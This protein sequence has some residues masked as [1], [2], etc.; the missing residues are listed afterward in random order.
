[1][2]VRGV[3]V[4]GRRRVFW[5]VGRLCVL[6]FRSSYGGRFPRDCRVSRDSDKLLCT[7][8]LCWF[9]FPLVHFGIVGLEDIE[10]VVD[11]CLFVMLC[12]SLI[13]FSFLCLIP[14][15][16]SRFL[17]MDSSLMDLEPNN[18][19]WFYLFTPQPQP[20]EPLLC[21]IQEE[22]KKNRM[23]LWYEDQ[24]SHTHP[25]HSQTCWYPI[26]FPLLRD[27]LPPLHL[28]CARLLDPQVLSFSLSWHR[29][30]YIYVFPWSLT[31]SIK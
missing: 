31:L 24:L 13:L 26:F 7:V 10:E 22:Q 28:V 9:W 5:W 14:I 3:G 23:F 30:P 1:M 8:W 6:W 25:S 11:V 12:L 29:P 21:Y 27:P 16:L 2:C 18:S 17:S 15:L 4:C 19:S 20:F